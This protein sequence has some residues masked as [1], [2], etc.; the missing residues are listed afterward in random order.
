MCSGVCFSGPHSQWA[1]SARPSLFRCFLNPQWPAHRRK[2]VVWVLLSRVLIWSF[3]GPYQVSRLISASARFVFYLVYLSTQQYANCISGTD[4]LW[5]FDMLPH[6]NKSF[7]SNLLSLPFN[8]DIK[9]S[10]PNTVPVMSGAWQ[11]GHSRTMYFASP[12]YDWMGQSG[13]RFPD[14]CSQ[15]GCFTTRLQRWCVSPGWLGRLELC[16]VV[17]MDSNPGTTLAA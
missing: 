2:M 8:T 12:L 7:Q 15:G 1:E 13:D 5:Q 10:G 6:W 9:T 3:C 14:F 17:L 11:G 4:P 16:C